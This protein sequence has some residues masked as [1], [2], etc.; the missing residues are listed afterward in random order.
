MG[1]RLVKGAFGVDDIRTLD[2]T[3]PFGRVCQ[4]EDVAE[5]V[6]FLVSD[7]GEYLTGQRIYVDGGGML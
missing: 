5:V 6:R 3:S 4:P 1:R 2:A 7:A